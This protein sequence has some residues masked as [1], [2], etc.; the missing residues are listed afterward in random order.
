[1]P[2]AL[3]H[4]VC[5]P[6]RFNG[7]DNANPERSA[8]ERYDKLILFFMPQCLSFIFFAVKMGNVVR[9]ALF[10]HDADAFVRNIRAGA[11]LSCKVYFDSAPPIPSPN[12][13]LKHL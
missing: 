6:A 1:M 11:G 2:S 9:F 8:N 10:A 13:N 3:Q 4:V 12:V 5:Q 7:Q